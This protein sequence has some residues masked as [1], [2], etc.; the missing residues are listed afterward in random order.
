MSKTIEIEMEQAGNGW[1]YFYVKGQESE[2][3]PIVLRGDF[4]ND[5]GI[6]IGAKI[7]IEEAR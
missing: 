6:L 4:C 1:V 2:G 3:Y 7:T 5:H